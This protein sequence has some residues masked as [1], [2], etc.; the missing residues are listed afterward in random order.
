MY[1][2]GKT[3]KIKDSLQFLRILKCVTKRVR[4]FARGECTTKHPVQDF[5]RFEETFTLVEFDFVKF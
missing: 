4:I 1:K 5:R 3:T 2:G